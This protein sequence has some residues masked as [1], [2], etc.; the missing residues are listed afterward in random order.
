MTS[1]TFSHDGDFFA[2]GGADRQ[3][4][5]WKSNFCKDDKAPRNVTKQLIPPADKL[6]FN[7]DVDEKSSADSARKERREK[8][9]GQE[10]DQ[11]VII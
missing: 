3:V 5:M 11:E 1:I 10:R 4:L 7:A 8:D 9:A 6:K 2:S